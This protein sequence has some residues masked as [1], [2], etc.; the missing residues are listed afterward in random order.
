MK[1]GRCKQVPPVA[2]VIPCQCHYRSNDQS[3][4]ESLQ[5]Y[6]HV[7]NLIFYSKRSK[8][9]RSNDQWSLWSIYCWDFTRLQFYVR[10]INLNFFSF[11]RLKYYLSNVYML[12]QNERVIGKSITYAQEISRD[13]RYFPSFGGVCTTSPQYWPI[14]RKSIPVDRERLTDSVKIN[15]SLLIMR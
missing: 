10:V 6:V 4:A 8:D 3:T 9:Y 14:Y 7:I 13:P 12:P 5:F 1:Q 11:P 15:P 2:C